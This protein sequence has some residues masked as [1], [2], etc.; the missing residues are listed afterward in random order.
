MCPGVDD[1]TIGTDIPN[2]IDYTKDTESTSCGVVKL[3]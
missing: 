3:T 2:V 1:T